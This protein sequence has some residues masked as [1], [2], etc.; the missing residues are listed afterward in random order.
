MKPKLGGIII[1]IL[2]PAAMQA[3]A[4]LLSYLNFSISG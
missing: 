1:P 3:E 2:P 4:S